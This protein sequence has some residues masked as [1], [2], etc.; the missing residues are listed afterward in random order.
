MNS[1]QEVDLTSREFREEPY[2]LYAPRAPRL[3]YFARR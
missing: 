3:R 2:P 1:I